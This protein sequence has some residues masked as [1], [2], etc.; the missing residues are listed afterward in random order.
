M[1]M[2]FMRPYNLEVMS[3][4]WRLA[5]FTGQANCLISLVGTRARTWDPLIKRRAISKVADKFP[6]RF[7]REFQTATAALFELT[8]RL[9]IET[10]VAAKTR[11]NSPKRNVADV[12]KMVVWLGDRTVSRASATPAGDGG[13]R[14]KSCSQFPYD[15]QL[16]TS[17]SKDAS[18]SER[19]EF[20]SCQNRISLV[21]S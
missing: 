3:S 21:N 6:N 1:A 18:L 10:G 13:P 17:G 15:P 4:R 2:M 11:W 5:L 9:R 20:E 12:V 19:T 14:H 16:A 8:S 7:N